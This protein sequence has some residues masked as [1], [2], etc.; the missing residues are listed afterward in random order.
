MAQERAVDLARRAF[1]LG[2]VAEFLSGKKG[3]AVPISRFVSANVP[4]DF[5]IILLVGVFK[6]YN[7]RKDDSIRE[8]YVKAIRQ[9]LLSSNCVDIWCAYSICFFQTC[10]EARNKAPFSIMSSE[11]ISEVSAAL[12]KNKEIL[13]ACHLWQGMGRTNGLWQ[14]IETSNNVLLNKYGVSLT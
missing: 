14:D 13:G 3:Y 5:E 7:E 10:F 2:E 9:L 11:L 12:K 6:Y 1:E 8:Q 4:T